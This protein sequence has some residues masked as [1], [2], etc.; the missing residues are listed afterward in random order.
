ML[1]PDAGAMRVSFFPLAATLL[2][3][4]GSF[5]CASSAASDGYE[6][7]DFG[8]RSGSAPMMMQ[9]SAVA[10]DF[11]DDAASGQMMRPNGAMSRSAPLMASPPAEQ[12]SSSS[13]S[14]PSDK[15]EITEAAKR[16]VIYT[17]SVATIVPQLEPG[18]ATFIAKVS[19]DGGYLQ[20]RNGNSVTVRVP[21]NGFF[22]T[23]DWLKKNGQVTDENINAVDVTKRVFD[24][25]LRLQTADEARKRLLKL[26]ENAT[27]MEDILKI[28]A[29]VRR[30]T[31]E[32]E[33]MKGEL[34]NLGDQVAFST[35]TVNFFADAPPPN[36]YPQRTRSRF[37]WINQVGLERVLGSF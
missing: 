17:G 37:E 1:K 7:D 23:I 15:G 2:T 34:R 21:A 5:G 11:S 8:A 26:L 28:E 29:E 9:E 3:V 27:K 19:A 16:L 20:S 14:S 32:I 10:M 24:L 12:P 35:L 36:P 13:S 31:D 22:A 33:G 6:G 30:L 18:L 25:E 4:V